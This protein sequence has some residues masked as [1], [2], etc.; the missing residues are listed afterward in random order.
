MA[1]SVELIVGP[2]RSGKA[3]GILGAYTQA[4]AQAGPGK[5]L[6]LVPTALRR[7]ATES[8]LLA[9]Q[10]SGVLVQPQ[11]LEM[12]E[13]ADR[14]LS[15]AGRPVRRIS[16]LARRQVI[17]G[18][19]ARLD[20]KQATVLG[21]VRDAP[22]LVDA[23]D[24]LFRE[25]KA[26]RVEPDAFGS[27]LAGGL[28]TPRNRLLAILY[29]AYQK[30][31]QSLEVYDDA[32]QFW[33]AAALVAEGHFGG[34]D[35]LALLV[36][37]GF[38]DFF[39][40]QLDMLEA[41]AARAERTIL[42]L[43][44]EPSRPGLFGVTERTRD[45]LRKRFGKRLTET[46]VDK[47]S[48]LAPDLE[49]V[50]THLFLPPNAA[51]PQA[52]K[53]S[54][55]PAAVSIRVIR[56][57]GRTREVE[58]VAREIVDLLR[59]GA[60]RPASIAV[61]VRSHDAYAS[62][63]RSIFPRYGLPFRVE[64]GR[65]LGDCPI[66]R[67]AMSLVRLQVEG[68]SFRALARVITS[69][70]FSPE[71]FG[72]D[73]ETARSAVR[74]AR[75]ANVWEGRE[76]YAERFESLKAMAL[77][78]ADAVNAAG[79]PVLAPEKRAERIAAIDRAAALVERLF[80]TLALPERGSRSAL[81]ARLREVVRAADLWTVARGDA[82]P[83]GRARDLKAMM[84]LEEV[85][86][87]VALLDEGD[88]AEVTLAAFLTEVEQGLALA[89][90]PSEEP[91]DAPVLVLDVLQ[92]RALSFD[93][94]FLLGVA[95]K[96]FPRRGRRHPFF[97]DGERRD[98]RARGVDLADTGLDAAHE[99]LLFYLAVT[100][101]RRS[102]VVSYPSL[103]AQGRPA[104]PSHYLEELGGL[105]ASADGG[106][107][108]PVT[109]VEARDLALP[110]ERLRSGRELLASTMFDLWGPGKSTLGDAGAAILDGMLARG[111]AA[112]T[113]LAGLAVEWERE[114]GDAFGP[115]DGR[116]ASADIIEELC[117]RYP[118][119][120]A[121]SASRLDAFG[122][123]PFAFL[124]SAVL[125]LD[126][127]EEPSP[128][129]GPLEAGQIYHGLLQRF[130]AA[131]AE[132]KNLGGRITPETL[133]VA[134]AL[135]TQTAAAYFKR[136]EAYGRVGS[137]A[138][139]KIQ[140]QNILRDVQR[141]VAWHAENLTEWRAAYM[142]VPFGAREGEPLTPPGRREPITV[143]SP[144][145]PI[146][147]RGRIDRIDLADT[148]ERGYAVVDYKSGS[149]P[150]LKAMST[151]T[152]FQLP[153]YLWAAE[154]LLGAA[155]KGPRRFAFFLPIRKPGQVGLIATERIGRKGWVKPGEALDRAAEYIRRFTDAMRRGFFPV[156]PRGDCP[157]YCHF[158]E[159]CRYAKWR[160]SR[161]WELHPIPE[162]A[163]VK[164]AADDAEE[165][166]A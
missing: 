22:G 57:A 36:A 89:K 32:G 95:E 85:L 160:V 72:A 154:A 67:A 99:M 133:D 78:G 122:A 92:S 132:S 114:H 97:D 65:P 90:V 62:L 49:R 121:M 151:G 23:L 104:L 140:K 113:A 81:A 73:L 93:H 116:L 123:C 43:T 112:E 103:D 6:M 96:E 51:P 70:Y 74:L 58:E 8:R 44:W 164:D 101:A 87:D 88:A 106:P 108:L 120:A 80:A 38:Q 27:A 161:K 148:G 14:L 52:G 149:A 3:G 150:S 134:R 61:I 40:A 117:R 7:R 115:F 2:A 156:Y 124:A 39:P 48:D 26:A 56:A 131:V 20:A 34:F 141:L 60:T 77:R 94:V 17:R 30:A 21:P 42:T 28:R 142:E 18:C 69:S 82:A 135:L 35:H 144:H 91:R 100:R 41:L 145:G 12:H 4:L 158:H 119:H 107:P 10:P 147:I 50:R 130:F 15:A 162:L 59:A 5:C 126:P 143:D 29:D 45:R 136:L 16:E 1:S 13:L 127:L 11:V 105:F 157:G 64:R 79:D 155:E 111:P 109:E 37:D 98:L 68:Y 137:A 139:W 54:A 76:R 159:I 66:V 129:L 9:S 24:H 125:D 165:A 86:D 71:A 53:K 31:L 138:L 63:V 25:L 47:P 19:L 55:A 46:V 153:I 75:E 118:G 33:H 84:A 110:V 166:D 146:R 128:D 102:L 152:S 83:E 163:V